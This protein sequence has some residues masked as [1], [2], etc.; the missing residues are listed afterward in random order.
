MV[1]LMLFWRNPNFVIRP[2]SLLAA[3]MFV[4]CT[5]VTYGNGIVS[6]SDYDEILKQVQD[7]VSKG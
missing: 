5:T 4:V 2:I 7:D 3:R 6:Y 1:Q